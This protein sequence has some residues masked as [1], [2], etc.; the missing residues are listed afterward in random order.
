MNNFGKL[1]G[2]HTYLTLRNAA[3]RRRMKTKAA[4]C[5]DV[6]GLVMNNQ[7]E[8]ENAGKRAETE[9]MKR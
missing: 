1:R 2:I 9:R 3:F 4:I 8:A 6:D 5:D 7:N